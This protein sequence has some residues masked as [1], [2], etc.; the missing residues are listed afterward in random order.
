VVPLKARGQLLRKAVRSRKV[1]EMDRLTQFLAGYGHSLAEF[2]KTS[3]YA[4][5]EIKKAA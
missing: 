4:F 5:L 1:L 2:H 3:S